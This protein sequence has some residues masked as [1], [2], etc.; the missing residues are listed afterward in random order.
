[1]ALRPLRDDHSLTW[2]QAFEK[3]K[4]SGYSLVSEYIHLL[5]R[6]IST[7]THGSDI[8]LS[9]YLTTC[10]Y[11]VYIWELDL[12]VDVIEFISLFCVSVTGSISS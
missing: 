3:K 4:R 8:G 11:P 2:L 1:M 5:R 6:Y 12:Y 7:I 10:V 9:V